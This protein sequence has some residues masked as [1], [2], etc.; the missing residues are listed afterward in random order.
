VQVVS[1][2][3]VSWCNWCAVQPETFFDAAEWT[4]VEVQAG[5]EGLAGQIQPSSVGVRAFKLAYTRGQHRDH[6][7][8]Q[9]YDWVGHSSVKIDLDLMLELKSSIAQGGLPCIQ[10]DQPAIKQAF[11]YI[12]TCEPYLKDTT[13]VTW[14]AIAASQIGC[15]THRIQEAAYGPYFEE[16]QGLFS[17]MLDL[18]LPA[19][20]LSG[21]D[22]GEGGLKPYAVLLLS[23]LGYISA[24]QAAEIRRFVGAGGGLIAT[25]QTSLIGED[26]RPLPDFA[27][28]DVLGVSAGTEPDWDI[29]PAKWLEGCAYLDFG[30]NEPWWGDAVQPSTSADAGELDVKNRRWLSSRQAVAIHSPFQVV[31]AASGAVVEASVGSTD[32]A[33]SNR[34]PGIVRHGYGKGKVV[35]IAPCLGQIYARYPYTMW[36]RV[37]RHALDLVAPRPAGVAVSA[38][39]C[40]TAYA[41][42]QPPQR[43]WIVHLINDLDETGRP[44]GRM[45]AG[46]NDQAGSF[47]RTRTIPV[48]GVEVI[49]RKPG[50]TRASLPLEGR[51]LAVA[52]RD[53][54]LHI[55][56]G[57]VDQHTLIVVD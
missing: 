26:G 7:K 1:N 14:A 17:A 57:R 13:P 24:P 10:G 19:E 15:D 44:R 51:E 33:R 46:R 29:P 38:P 37:L 52:Q 22:L 30:D 4:C 55:Q 6:R 54:A 3:P 53:G 9:A 27:L 34:Y 49:V 11:D 45:G 42:E 32:P 47:P 16:V 28:A 48:D 23:D 35:Y 12:R 40:V 36:Q 31:K 18:R 39:Q 2:T 20:F 50:A 25:G 43:R 8:V 5:A 56:V 41:W 21:R